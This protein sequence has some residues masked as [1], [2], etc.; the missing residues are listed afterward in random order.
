MATKKEEIYRATG[1]R[2]CSISKVIIK[3]GSGKYTVNKRDFTNYFHDENTR[4]M[5]EQPLEVVEGEE[6]WDITIFTHGGGISGQAGATRLGISRALLAYNEE[7]RK[8][9]RENKLLT[10]DSRI[11]QR[12]MYG[13]AK[14][15]K[16][17]QFSKR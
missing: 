1:R 7:N 17:F 4:K 3:K 15:R 13:R 2:K 8:I 5:I 11:V 10:R 9:L 16:R 14:A 12:K 6:T